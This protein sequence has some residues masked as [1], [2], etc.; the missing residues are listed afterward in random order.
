MALQI[1]VAGPVTIQ[2][3][4]GDGLETLGVCLDQPRLVDRAFY[5]DVHADSHGGPQGPPI[6]VQYL[7]RLMLARLDLSKYDRAVADKVRGRLP[8][9]AAGQVASTEIGTLLL[10][11]ES[12]IRVLLASPNDPYNFPTCI[13]REAVEITVGA[14]FST[15]S[16][17]FTAYPDPTTGLLYNAETD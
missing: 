12:T 15:F 16:L 17:E 2:V 5:Y 1:H 8:G 9:G 7:G 6:D 3:D 11:S 4:A 14:K 13:V 10:Q